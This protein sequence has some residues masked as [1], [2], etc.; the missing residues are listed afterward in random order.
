M[1]NP[2]PNIILATTSIL[3]LSCAVK[4]SPPGGPE[5]T[6]APGIVGVDPEP[7]S[8]NLPLDSRFTVIFSKPMDKAKTEGSVFLS[9]V[10]WDYP[11]MKWSGRKLTVIP[12]E[13]LKPG[14]TYIL[15]IGAE[16]EDYHRN[17]IG[18]SHSYAFSTG[19]EIDSGSIAGAVYFTDRARKNC[20]IWAYAVSDT[21]DVQFL[22]EIPD[23]ATQ[24]DSLGGFDINSV[25][26][27]LYV[28][29]AVDDRN[30]DLF[31]DPTSESLGLPPFIVSISGN[32][33]VSGII[34]RPDRRDTSLVYISRARPVDNRK[35]EV[36]FSQPVDDR[37]MLDQKSYR[38]ESLEGSD[39]LNVLGTY[40]GQQGR[41]IL[42]T[43]LQQ[44]RQQYTLHTTALTSIW[45]NE[46][47]TAGARFEGSA[48][49]D[50]VG[51]SL[52]SVFPPDQST[53]VYEDSV[54]EMTFSERI[55]P[56]GI[57]EAITVVADSV[58]TLSF[59]P[60]L[61]APNKV[62]L[63]FGEGLPR[64]K[65]VGVAVK[66][67]AVLDAVGNPFTDTTAVFS[68]VLPP[69][70]TA[71]SVMVTVDSS[72]SAPVIGILTSMERSDRTYRSVVDDSGELSFEA[73]LPGAYWF[74]FF[75][76]S[77]GNGRWSP[78]I[79]R[80]FKVAER[81]T[82]LADS[83]SVRSRWT[84]DVGTMILPVPAGKK[85]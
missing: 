33:M 31:W 14:K 23:Y 6:T 49:G 28:V 35:L 58:D 3:L 52:L 2:I 72:G 18:K 64:G 68:F 22:T 63:R 30:D 34:L 71:G 69:A 39:T 26:P 55:N 48:I 73:V 60:F 29:V 42:E 12:P 62:R 54:I 65:T 51:P 59:A 47:D 36:E 21:F 19:P 66:P 25:S 13:S 32:A 8:T 85:D 82:F 83:V 53:D 17:K 78:G 10:F 79:V 1:K 84:T 45:G 20:D 67:G 70:D 11:R 15:T 46:F 4:E 77:D 80:P 9:P 5:D 50:S 76:D 24:V 81:F 37:L 40:K 16:C 44:S 27:G 56:L 7:G 61:A 43:G 75:E 41:L 74:E 38:I 57:S